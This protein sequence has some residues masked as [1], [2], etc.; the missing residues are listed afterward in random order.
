MKPWIINIIIVTVVFLIAFFV[1]PNISEPL[2]KLIIFAS[3]VWV[4]IDSKKIGIEKYKRTSFVFSTSSLGMAFSVLI[5]WIFTFPMYISWRR[6]A[7]NGEIPLKENQEQPQSKTE[8][9]A[10]IIGVTIAYL[11]G[12]LLFLFFVVPF[13]LGIFM[14]GDEPVDDSDMQLSIINIPEEENAFY[15]LIKIDDVINM[16]NLPDGVRSSYD[17][18]YGDK[19]N[20]DEVSILLDD[21]V[22]AL[23]YYD[24]AAK[25]DKFQ[26]TASDHPDKITYDMQIIS[27]NPWIEIS[28]L[29]G[30]KAIQ[31]AKEGKGDEAMEEAFKSVI[32]GDAIERS[33]ANEITY[34][35]GMAVKRNGFDFIQKVMS[36]SNISV[37]TLKRYQED[38]KKYDMSDNVSFLK[39]QYLVVKSNILTVLPDYVD[40]FLDGSW[41][42][43]IFAVFSV[44]PK[45]KYNIKPNSTVSYHLNAMREII[46]NFEKPCDDI[47]FIALDNIIEFDSYFDYIKLYYSENSIGKIL[48]ASPE[49]FLYNLKEKRCAHQDNLDELRNEIDTMISMAY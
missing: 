17:Y 1:S 24:S 46:F 6:K 10:N 14:G 39:V 16:E 30:I 33:Q 18:L 8:K 21:N 12:V 36:I 25:K 4:Y 19:W 15:D 40:G 29:S 11:F 44:T 13:V 28:R 47:D 26:S 5:L 38:L 43:P 49:T 32:I 37:D 7:L 34:L 48:Y 3:T 20:E 27:L 45:T 31:L 9:V 2:I 22:E 35:V 42:S 23:E 41:D